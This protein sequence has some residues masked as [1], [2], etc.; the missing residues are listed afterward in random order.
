MEAHG[1]YA[2]KL[3]IEM[4]SNGSGILAQ[5]DHEICPCDCSFLLRNRV[6]IMLQ[7]TLKLNS[8]ITFSSLPKSTHLSMR[9][10][11]REGVTWIQD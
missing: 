8:F 2:F 11:M 1:A 10:S 9:D 7:H 5:H 3:W 6:A 4:T